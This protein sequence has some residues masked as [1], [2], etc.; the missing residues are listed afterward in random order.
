MSAFQLMV[1]TTGPRLGDLEAGAV[2]ALVNPVFS[3]V[4]GDVACVVGIALLAI[5]VPEMRRQRAA[6]EDRP[7]AAQ[8]TAP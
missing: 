4:S 1:V 5:A 8:V 2:A 7:T 6:D 3:V